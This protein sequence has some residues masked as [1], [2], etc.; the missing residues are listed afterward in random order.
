MDKQTSC[1]DNCTY[2]K[3][4]HNYQNDS[5]LWTCRNFCQD[6]LKEN[7]PEHKY[8]IIDCKE[9]IRDIE[10]TRE[11]YNDIDKYHKKI[12]KEIQRHS[13]TYDFLIRNNPDEY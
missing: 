10:I 12:L 8:I 3:L 2:G 5:N 1:C 11:R 7:E 9:L 6:Y 13:D 4:F